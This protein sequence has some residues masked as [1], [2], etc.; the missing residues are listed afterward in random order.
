MNSNNAPTSQPSLGVLAVIPARLQSTRLPRK[1][2]R[3]LAGRPLL[4]WVVDAARACPQLDRLVIAVDSDEVAALCER[5][6]WPFQMTSPDLASGTDR[7]HAVAQTTPAEIYV[8]IQADEPLLTP[9]HLSALLAP[10]ANPAVQASTLKVPCPP[11]DITNP[12]VVKVVTALDGRAL[13]FSRA[14][15]PFDRDRT[16]TAPYWKHLGLYAYRRDTL[17]RFASLPPSPLESIERLE[18]LRLLENNIALH[19]AEAPSDTVGVDTE[20]GPPARR[21]HPAPALRCVPPARFPRLDTSSPHPIHSRRNPLVLKAAC[22]C[23]LTLVAGTLSGLAQSPGAQTQQPPS[24]GYTVSVNSRLVVEDVSVTDAKGNPVIDLPASAFHVFDNE[25]PQPKFDLRQT[26]A[27]VSAAVPSAPGTLT[28][29]TLL[30]DRGTMIAILIDPATIDL[31]D[32]MYL[33]VQALRFI[34]TLPQ[35]TEVTIFRAN[36]RGVPI[37]LQ[38]PTSDRALLRTALDMA[39]PVMAR[40]VDS[41]FENAITELGNLS[42]YLGPIPGRKAVLWLAGRFPLYEPPDFTL[43]AGDDPRRLEEIHEAFR[44]LQNARIAVYPIDVRGVLMGGL[45]PNIVINTQAAANDPSSIASAHPGRV[46]QGRGPIRDHGPDRRRHRR[47]CFLQQQRDQQGDGRGR[48]P[49]LRRL[50]PQLR[51]ARPAPPMANGT[52]FASPSTA[53]TPSTTAPATSPLTTPRPEARRRS[54][55]IPAAFCQP[56]PPSRAPPPQPSP[57]LSTSL[58]R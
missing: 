14:A 49:R 46:G 37:L 5:E 23:A 51:P 29:A 56:T 50:H 11:G 20:A 17:A 43:R 32:Q 3:E 13:Y 52:R 21:P 30:Q 33:R 10:F 6:G 44:T 55:L 34:E 25:K 45:A 42:A 54:T 24:P 35:S 7:L 48:S 2:L 47:P 15:I 1:V 16:G 38:P 18:Q 12:N 27:P 31:Q 8:N 9:A 4:A 28:N 26:S 58:R 39:V 57:P 19:V 53:L 36:N 41:T 22:R 40:P